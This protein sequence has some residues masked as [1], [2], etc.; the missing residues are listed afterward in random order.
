MDFHY[1]VDVTSL[2]FFPDGHRA[3]ILGNDSL[4]VW[5]VTTGT[6]LELLARPKSRPRGKE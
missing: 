6:P 5:D 2:S 4:E 3:L 1:G